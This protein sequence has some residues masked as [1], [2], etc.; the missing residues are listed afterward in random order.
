MGIKEL[1][2]GALSK[3]VN[4][5]YASL[6][7]ERQCS[8]QNWL[9]RQEELWHSRC[10]GQPVCEDFLLILFSEGE[11]TDQW[12]QRIGAYF[13]AH[14][15]ALVVY[16]D[17]DRLD[18]DG[19][20]A[21]PW[22]KPDWSPDLLDSCLYFG[23]LAAVRTEHFEKIRSFYD[24][25]DPKAFEELFGEDRRS[26][27]DVLR[28]TDLALGRRWLHTCVSTGY[29]KGAET[30]GH[31]REI[32]FRSAEACRDKF[33][34]ADSFCEEQKTELMKH[35]Y[36]EA[37]LQ[38]EKGKPIVSV[39]IPSK[40]HP[41]LLKQC[42]DGVRV[43]AEIPCQIIVVDNGSSEENRL[44]VEKLLQE[45]E[46]VPM[47]DV[48][49]TCEYLYQ[50]QEFHF[51]KMC[52]L[53]AEAA[54]AECLLFLNDDVIL[55]DGCIPELAA[56][57]GRAYTGAVGMKLLYPSDCRIQHAGITNLPMGP[58]HKLQTLTDDQEYYGRTNRL[59]GNFLAVTAACLMVEK[60]KFLEAGGF[61][62]SLAVAFNDVDL[63]Y[64]LYEAGYHNV[65]I[66]DRYAYHHESLSR[67]ADESAE[68][69]RRL[70]RE[71]DI[72]FAR[73][74]KLS[75]T[76]PYYSDDL[77]RDGLDVRIVPGYATSKNCCQKVTESLPGSMLSAY[78]EDPC[79]MVR[80]EDLRE[81]NL[82]GYTLVLSD[83]NSHYAFSLLLKNEDSGQVLVIPLERQFRPDLAENLPDQRNVELGGFWVDVSELKMMPGSYAIGMLAKNRVNRTR[84]LNWSNR[85]LDC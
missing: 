43:A 5:E 53:G 37:L 58:V 34:R 84:L 1:V 46:R 12:R 81:K 72:L 19:K 28:V 30:V 57:A 52:N 38:T 48:T 49:F 13:A 62:E 64:K 76:D 16:A 25:V 85:S 63:C 27:G 70:L 59:T 36:E 40:D 42:L 51:S 7:A 23:S 21:D 73:H 55:E 2:K 18:G 17:E 79:L 15:K 54:A 69:V 78:R 68:K 44:R 80:I 9:D 56:R 33:L 67:G 50:P 6:L 32:L 82:Y 66:N 45:M 47:G 29:A 4:K 39:I 10:Q 74:P 61:E 41:E 71:R 22:F 77:N 60:K 26:G 11:P 3:K 31:I 75:G 24:R 83:D 65:C 20:P 35:F 8:Y 14:P